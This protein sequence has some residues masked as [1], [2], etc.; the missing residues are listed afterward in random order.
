M[1]TDTPTPFEVS[2]EFLK[3]QGWSS[4]FLERFW[5]KVDKNGPIPEHVP[6]LGNCWV[7]TG[8]KHPFGYGKITTGIVRLHTIRAHVASWI[9]HFGP[10]PQGLQVNHACD[11]RDCTRPEHLWIGTQSDNGKDM[12]NKGRSTI[13]EKHPNAKL[14]EREVLEI[15]KRYF[16]GSSRILAVEFGVSAR[17]IRMIAHRD[18]WTRI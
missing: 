15:R 1:H 9:V 3:A 11:R 6:H 13:G 17:T 14:T 12:A 2:P 8:C 7:W 18:I 10:I 16:Q 5:N 4:T